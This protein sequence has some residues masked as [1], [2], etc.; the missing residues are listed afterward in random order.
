VKKVFFVHTYFHSL[1]ERLLSI[2]SLADVAYV[3]I[4][5]SDSDIISSFPTLIWKLPNPIHWCQ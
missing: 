4:L 2:L 1:T 3:S 5:V